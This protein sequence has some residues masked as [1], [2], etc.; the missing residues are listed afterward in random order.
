M[1]RKLYNELIENMAT[2]K[3]IVELFKNWHLSSKS[4]L[5]VDK[6][7]IEITA[8]IQV[9]STIQEIIT[10]VE[11]TKRPTTN[12]GNGLHKQN[13][14]GITFT[15]DPDYTTEQK[16]SKREQNGDQR[17]TRTRKDLHEITRNR[18]NPT[19]KKRKH[20]RNQA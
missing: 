3:Q 20:R 12:I 17:K 13:L 18:M 15:S 8:K 4:F 9:K 14:N 7:G 1:T 19:I 10:T 6:I 11:I 5:Q 2:I 16:I